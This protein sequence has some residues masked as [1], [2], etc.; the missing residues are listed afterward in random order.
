[1]DAKEVFIQDLTQDNFNW[2]TAG[3]GFTEE[4]AFYLGKSL[5]NLAERNQ[6]ISEIKFWGKINCLQNDYFIAYGRLRSF[7]KD[8][9]PDNWEPQGTGINQITFW[10]TNDC[11]KFT[12]EN[13]NWFSDMKEWIELPVIGPEHVNVARVVLYQF[14]GDLNAPVNT[15]IPFKGK[16]KHFLKA[17]LARITHNCEIVP[18]GV[19]MVN[20]EDGK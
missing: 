17:Q 2:N 9:C 20:D 18:G 6:N 12:K 11:K 1:M 10:A 19:F 7:V 4:E 16:E 13:F 5:A 8:T 3:Y 15:L 14:T